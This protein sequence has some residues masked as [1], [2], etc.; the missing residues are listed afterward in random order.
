MK[1]R[2][3]E[4]LA[5]ALIV[6]IVGFIVYMIIPSHPK[7]PTPAPVTVRSTSKIVSQSPVAPVSTVAVQTPPNTPALQEATAIGVS[8]NDQSPTSQVTHKG[9]GK[10]KVTISVKQSSRQGNGVLS[11]TVAQSSCTLLQKTVTKVESALQ[12]TPLIGNLF[13]DGTYCTS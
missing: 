13:T 6:S 11:A 3:G 8:Q 9:I 1:Q 12:G 10:N 7:T 5:L 2:F 4:L